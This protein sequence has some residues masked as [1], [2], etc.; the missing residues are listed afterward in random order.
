MGKAEFRAIAG[1][2][3]HAHAAVIWRGRAMGHVWA[4]RDDVKRGLARRHPGA[5][6][7]AHFVDQLQPVVGLDVPEG[8]AAIGECLPEPAG[9][10]IPGEAYVHVATASG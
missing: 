3:S 9:I 4:S 7:G 1:P 5:D 10:S 2:A 6:F 8:P